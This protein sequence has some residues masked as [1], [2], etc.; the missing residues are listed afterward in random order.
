MRQYL[1]RH[2]QSV[3]NREGRVQG[4]LDVPLSVIGESQADATAR[5]LVECRETMGIEEIWSSPLARAR[6][7]AERVAGA[8]GLPVHF[9]DRLKE[10]HAGI[11]Q[12][13]LWKDLDQ[14]FPDEM[15]RWRTGDHAYAIPEGES[16]LQLATRGRDVLHELSTRPVQGLL[17]VA[18]GG[19]LTAAIRLLV[20]VTG[21]QS[22]EGGQLP[23]MANTALSLLEW[24]G[25]S[26]V[27]FNDVSH[28]HPEIVTEQRQERL[29]E[30]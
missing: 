7:T 5:R 12:G 17:V 15:A 24:P 6:G 14:L 11:F 30:L 20:D 29:A 1:L 25:P 4:Q 21:H 27:S 13:R 26:L 23:P 3:S 22:L 16:R 28:L 18:H 19:V 2:G 8:L 9:D 10:L